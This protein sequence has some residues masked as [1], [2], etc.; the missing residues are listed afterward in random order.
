MGGGN[1]IFVALWQVQGLLE[2]SERGA[3]LPGTL[4][5]RGDTTDHLELYVSG[6]IRPTPPCASLPNGR[7]GIGAR[8]ARSFPGSLRS[9]Y[10][11]THPESEREGVSLIGFWQRQVPA[12]RLAGARWLSPGGDNA[13]QCASRKHMLVMGYWRSAQY[14]FQSANDYHSQ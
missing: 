10:P 4:C 5:A 13:V 8:Y 7:S 14:L 11:P 9:R 3:I 2:L 12:K 1:R 6:A